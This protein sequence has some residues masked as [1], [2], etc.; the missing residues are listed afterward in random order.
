VLGSVEP[1]NFQFT[2]EWRWNKAAA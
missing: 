1:F 2:T